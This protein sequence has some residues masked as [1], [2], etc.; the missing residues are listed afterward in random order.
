LEAVQPGGWKSTRERLPEEG[1][2][3]LYRTAA[4][5]AMGRYEGFNCWVLSN[6]EIEQGTVI[7]WQPL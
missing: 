4:H 7:L 3:V 5:Q 2:T 6:G 1:E